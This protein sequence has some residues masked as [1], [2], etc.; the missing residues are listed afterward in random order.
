MFGDFP[1]R[2]LGALSKLDIDLA[3]RVDC[4]SARYSGAC[5]PSES[6]RRGVI[7]DF[8]LWIGLLTFHVRKY[9]IN[10]STAP[11]QRRSALIK[12]FPGIVPLRDAS[13]V[14]QS[15]GWQR[16]TYC[17]AVDVARD[18]GIDVYRRIL[19]VRVWRARTDRGETSIH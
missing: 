11:R 17:G 12:R 13:Y 7:V 19:D 16:V 6:E 18:I 1:Q 3:S 8:E 5:C 9:R 4:V 10:L 2:Y 15:G 14:S